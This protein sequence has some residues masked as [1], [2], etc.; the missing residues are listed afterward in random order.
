MCR[1]PKERN[2]N[3]QSFLSKLSPILT[4]LEKYNDAII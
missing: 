3:D 1:P 2:E 4:H